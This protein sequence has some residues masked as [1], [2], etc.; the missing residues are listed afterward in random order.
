MLDIV[1][2]ALVLLVAVGVLIDVRVRALPPEEAAANIAYLRQLLSRQAGAE[3]PKP[4]RN[5]LASSGS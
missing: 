4:M 2:L 5:A 1:L 3:S